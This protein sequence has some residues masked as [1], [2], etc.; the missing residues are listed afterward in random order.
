MTGE[1]DR[2]ATALAALAGRGLDVSVK[3][4]P[5]QRGPLALG[6]VGGRRWNLLRGDLTMPAAVLSRSALAR[7]SRWMRDFAEK[8]QLS[9]APH[10]K[11]TLSPQLF[12]LQ[13]RD[14]AFAITVSNVQ[15]VALCREFGFDR[16]LIANQIV[17]RAE[18]E[19]LFD[20]IERSPGAEIFLLV[21]SREGVARL[22]AG[23]RGRA[24]AARLGLLIE[25]GFAGGRTGAR[26]LAA[27]LDVARAVREAGLS[28]RGVEGFEGLL[29]TPAEV[30]VFLGF[31][32]ETAAACRRDGLFA[33]GGGPVLLSAGGTAY[34]DRVAVK[35]G[36]HGFAGGDYRL[37]TRSGCYLTHDS[38]MYA[39][40]LRDM[41]ARDDG[42]VLPPDD[43]VPALT[44]W[45]IVQ[46][47]PEPGRAILTMG[48]RDVGF[49]A[50]LPVPLLW[51]RDGLHARPAPLAEGHAIAALNDQ[52]GYLACPDASPLAVGDLIA[53]GISHPCTTFD[54]WQVLFVVDDDWTVVDAIKTFF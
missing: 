46:S 28:L 32:A 34:F 7:N 52:H 12:D 20:E 21:D 41:H 50:G 5:P 43:L 19:Y 11:T 49:D 48:R 39:Q 54:K 8:N 31:L 1:T 53:C 16:I 35:L 40:A 26:T 4:I 38:L 14:G 45:T 9:L 42:H 2:R 15:Q 33:D 22:A 36:Q 30:D 27:A 23:A 47:R 51:Y 37:V 24:S 29:G 3:G 10:G 13:A 18:I 25:V 44:V 6:E 17:G